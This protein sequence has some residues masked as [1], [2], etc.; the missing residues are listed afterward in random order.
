[1]TLHRIDLTYDDDDG[2]HVAACIC[3]W[4]SPAYPAIGPARA[5]GWGH[6]DA[7]VLAAGFDTCVA[8]HS[9]L[10]DPTYCDECGSPQ[11]DDRSGYDIG[12]SG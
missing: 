7:A 4:K 8:C 5:A 12:G 10:D 9:A 6:C 11:P 2:Q 1:M 3:G